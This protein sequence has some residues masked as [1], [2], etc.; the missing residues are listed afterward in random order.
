LIKC[1]INIYRCQNNQSPTW[2]CSGRIV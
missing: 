1:N 2:R